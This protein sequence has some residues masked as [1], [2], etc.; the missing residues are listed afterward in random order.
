MLKKLRLKFIC[1]NM[2]MITA[3]LVAILC[4]VV[5]ITKQD[6]EKTGMNIMQDLAMHPWNAKQPAKK[7]DIRSPYLIVRLN[8]TTDRNDNSPENEALSVRMSE[9]FPLSDAA[10]ISELIQ[11]ALDSEHMTG[12]ISEYRLRFSRFFTPQEQVVVFL[13]ISGEQQLLSVLTR[14]C[15]MLGIA[16]FFVFLFINI[17]FARWA[18]KPVET[19][20]S[21]QN[22]FIADASH[23]L[24]TPLTVI[25]T[26]AELL[27]SPDY[28][29][30]DKQRF[31]EH[32]FSMAVQMR[33]LVEG[34]L[35]LSRAD[36]GSMQLAME[37]LNFHTLLE[38]TLCVFEP[39][40]FEHGLTLRSEIA[41]DIRI[42]G[43][44][45]H[46]T[47][48][49]DILLDNALKYADRESEILVK[50]QRQHHHCLLSVTTSGDPI[51]P[52]D[53][54]RIFHRFY[55]LDKS[56]S[57]SGSYGLGLSI[58]ENIIQ[59]HEGKIWAESGAQS[60]TFFVR[61]QVL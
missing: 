19:A 20:W 61:L 45:A 35:D 9:N 34:L 28:G 48:V 4:T 13:D 32:I 44:P 10:D 59:K 43:S 18:V 54:K 49:I 1:M 15:I 52:E 26:N 40:Y 12:I 41:N 11:T 39:L 56:R 30:D 17:L 42:M 7:A 2:A 37:R 6:L 46:L 21:N 8:P 53:L 14:N 55:R 60:N 23:E 3:I 27:R 38:Q 58:A 47:Q 29:A 16:G 33:T 31:S 22:Q 5:S 51:P 25:L 36:N 57:H 24:K 50:L